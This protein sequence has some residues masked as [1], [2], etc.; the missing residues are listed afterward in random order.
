MSFLWQ[1]MR[2][3]VENIGTV[4]FDSGISLSGYKGTVRSVS[5]LLRIDR[6]YSGF[7]QYSHPSKQVKGNKLFN[8]E[9]N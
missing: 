4:P 8:S 3:L 1:F 6:I 7:C 9:K 2:P 5:L